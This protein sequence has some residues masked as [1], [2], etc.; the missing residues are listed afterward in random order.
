M[1]KNLRKIELNQ[2]CSLK[3]VYIQLQIAG[4]DCY[5][6]Y[7]GNLLLSDNALDDIYVKVTG[8]KRIE[9]YNNQMKRRFELGQDLMKG[10]AIE[11]FKKSCPCWSR[12][13][14]DRKCDEC[15]YLKDFCNQLD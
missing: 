1:N 8:W 4:C 6:E 10:K 7:K 9:L 2:E 11:V 15:A 13:Q 14:Q 5:G 12:F 3:E